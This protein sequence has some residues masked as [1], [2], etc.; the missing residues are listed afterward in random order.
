M[1]SVA[2]L[3]L[4]ACTACAAAP[5]RDASAA[6]EKITLLDASGAPLPVRALIGEMPL[7]AFVFFSAHCPCQ[8]AH[9][10]RLRTLMARFAGRV[11]IVLVDSE[12]GASFEREQAEARR[13]GYAT[14]PR[15]DREAELAHAF[16]VE[17]ATHVVV[18]DRQG[19]IR[20]S[21]GIDSDR[22]HLTADAT[23][24]LADALDELLAGRTPPPAKSGPLG[25]ALRTNGPLSP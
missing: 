16:G 9:D 1:R 20:Y 25:C 8:T 14:P 11:N 5:P 3:V 18:V 13:R 7:T 2:A 24:F 21:G 12:V 19:R 17:S 4:L 10:A 22:V 23:P 15:I 6:L